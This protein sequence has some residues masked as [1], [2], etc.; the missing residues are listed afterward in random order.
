VLAGL[1]ARTLSG[2]GAVPKRVKFHRFVLTY[3]GG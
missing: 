3:R 2:A 1:L